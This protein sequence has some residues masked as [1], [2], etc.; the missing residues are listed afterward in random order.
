MISAMKELGE[1]ALAEGG[2]AVIGIVSYYKK[3]VLLQR[4]PV[5]NAT[6]VRWSPGVALERHSREG[7]LTI[8][9]SVHHKAERP[10]H[11]RANCP[12]ASQAPLKSHARTLL[13]ADRPP[14]A[15]GRPQTAPA[16]YRP[17]YPSPS[18]AAP[19]PCPKHSYAADK[20]GGRRNPVPLCPRAAR[21]TIPL[22]HL[23]GARLSPSP[24]PPRARVTHFRHPTFR[25][26]PSTPPKSR[27][28]L[29]PAPPNA[30]TSPSTNRPV[31]LK[32]TNI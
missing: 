32:I 6:P 5:S 10:L 29:T 24:P 16:S 17:A 18:C 1:Q 25:S 31:S 26:P 2:N 9:E 30:A 22:R 11:S 3:N 14:P 7:P 21:P 15:A 27:P 20:N 8:T 28:P 19:P 13:R 12:H 23:I 4:D